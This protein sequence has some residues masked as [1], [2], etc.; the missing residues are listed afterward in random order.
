MAMVVLRNLDWLDRPPF[1]FACWKELWH[2]HQ[3]SADRCNVLDQEQPA[4]SEELRSPRR[5]V[6]ACLCCW[7]RT[8]WLDRKPLVVSGACRVSAFGLR[9]RFRSDQAVRR[10]S[11][12]WIWNTIRRRLHFRA[13]DHRNCEPELAECRRNGL[14]FRR[15]ARS[16]LGTW[17]F[18][19]LASL[20][21]SVCRNGHH[22]EP[23]TRNLP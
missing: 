12:G 6:D 8:W 21:K 18:S 23:E 13:R 9:W 16:H 5:H 19:V 10:R 11:T 17:Q 22:I 20:S 1:V 4:L 3:L 14:L 2:L 15:W 7:H